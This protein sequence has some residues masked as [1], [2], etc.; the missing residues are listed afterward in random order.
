MLDT[1]THSSNKTRPQYSTFSEAAIGLSPADP[2]RTRGLAKGQASELRTTKDSAKISANRRSI[3]R[4][5]NQAAVRSALRM[6]GP[7]DMPEPL[8]KLTIVAHEELTRFYNIVCHAGYELCLRDHREFVIDRGGKPTVGSRLV[9]WGSEKSD[10]W[11]RPLEKRKSE[12][13][14]RPRPSDPHALDRRAVQSRCGSRGGAGTAVANCEVSVF[15]PAGNF[16]GSLELL[17]KDRRQPLPFDGMARALLEATARAIEERLFRDQYRRE[18]IVMASP[19]EIPGSG[20]LFAVDRHQ[21]IVAADR[22]AR[23]VLTA[24]SALEAVAHGGR[25]SLWTLFEKDLALFRSRDRRDIPAQLIPAGSAETWSALITPPDTDL[26]PWRELEASLHTR[27]RI[28]ET[29]FIRQLTG[30][31]VARGGLS[32]NVLRR[33]REYIDA[34]LEAN[35]GLDA[36][37]KV[38]GLSRCH[39]VRAFRQSVGTT[40]HNFLMYRRFCKAVDFITGTDLPLAEIALAAGFSDQSHFSRRFRQYLGVSPSAFRRSQR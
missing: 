23:S 18:W 14:E 24:N 6:D 16:I 26:T 28:G 15:D 38:A 39:F 34:N 9:E 35:I 1:L 3:A 25:I 36:I 7:Y 31:P 19:Q 11:P 20:M 4:R 33:V 22:Q 21:N 27:P 13:T 37:S 10:R 5:Y 32:P 17:P 8:S 30:A 40:P 2:A 12:T 29:G